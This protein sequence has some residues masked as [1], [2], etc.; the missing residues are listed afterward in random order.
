MITGYTGCSI[1]AVVSLGGLAFHSDL[2]TMSEQLGD[3]VVASVVVVLVVVGVV[4]G[5]S[6]GRL[7]VGGGPACPTCTVQ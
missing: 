6:L 2:D 4:V 1:A 3:S 7:V 5:L